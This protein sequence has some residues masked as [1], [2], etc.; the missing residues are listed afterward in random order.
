MNNLE[1]GEYGFLFLGATLASKTMVPKE[2]FELSQSYDRGCL[3]PLRLPNSATQAFYFDYNNGCDSGSGGRDHT[4]IFGPRN[5]VLVSRRILL[6]S[7]WI[8]TIALFSFAVFKLHHICY[9][10][11]N[12]I[13]HGHSTIAQYHL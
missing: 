5:R 7:L 6:T 13:V 12:F 1:A 3:K 10:N 4:D 11:V 8:F 9:F 2:R